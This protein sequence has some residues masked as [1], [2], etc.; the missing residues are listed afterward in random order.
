MYFGAPEL[1]FLGVQLLTVFF[2]HVRTFIKK[3][4]VR[5]I[6][7]ALCLSKPEVPRILKLGT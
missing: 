1:D 3:I 2:I 7:V 4:I 6:K 5:K